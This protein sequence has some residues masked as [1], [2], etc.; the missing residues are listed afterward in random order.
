MFPMSVMTIILQRLPYTLAL[1]L[2]VL[3]LSFFLGNWIGA[4]AAYVGGKRSE[5]VYF[6]SVF[7]NRL[8]SFWFGMVLVFVFAAS[9]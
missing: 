1:V 4:K 2:P 9:S 3:F 8:P 6:F 5:L 7:S